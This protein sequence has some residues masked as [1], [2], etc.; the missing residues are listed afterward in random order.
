MVSSGTD[1]HFESEDPD[2]SLEAVCQHVQTHF[3]RDVA[4]IAGLEVG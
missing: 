4:Q 3:G 2:D 1:P